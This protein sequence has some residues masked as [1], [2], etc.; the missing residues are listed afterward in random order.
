[1]AWTAHQPVRGGLLVLALA[2]HRPQVVLSRR[3]ASDAPPSPMARRRQDHHEPAPHRLRP[4]APRARL[5]LARRSAVEIAAMLGVTSLVIGLTVVAAGTSMP[6][7]VTSII[8]GLRGQRDIAVGNVIGSNIF[9]L[10][11][12]LGF[13]GFLVPGGIPVPPPHSPS[14]SPSWSPSPS[15]ACPSSS[16]TPSAGGKAHLPRLLPALH[17]LPHRRRIPARRSRP[18]PRRRHRR[19]RAAHPH[20]APRRQRPQ[21]LPPRRPPRRPDPLRPR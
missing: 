16:A 17:I 18:L 8:A 1:M 10:L 14:T 7:V 2:V 6:E 15:C 3:S 19:R 13:T 9:N 12:V 20:L 5:Q 11:A 4:R 21:P